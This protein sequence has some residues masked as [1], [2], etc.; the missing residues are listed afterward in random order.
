MKQTYPFSNHLRKLLNLVAELF[1]LGFEFSTINIHW[2]A[3]SAF[4]EPIEGFSVGKHPQKILLD[5][6]Y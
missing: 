3:I 6:G 2:S 5:V 1:E 4:H